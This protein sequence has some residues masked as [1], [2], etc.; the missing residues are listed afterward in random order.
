MELRGININKIIQQFGST[1]EFIIQLEVCV[2][3]ALY[4]DKFLLMNIIIYYN[5]LFEIPIELK[6]DVIKWAGYSLTDRLYYINQELKCE[7]LNFL[8]ELNE[9]NLN[10]V[11]KVRCLA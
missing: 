9:Y 2:E 7:V 4:E 8:I 1:S 11:K 5:N 6:R 3:R 10:Y